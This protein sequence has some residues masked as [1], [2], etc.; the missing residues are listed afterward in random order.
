MCA[1]RKLNI[2]DVAPAVEMFAELLEQ[3]SEFQSQGGEP[4]ASMGDFIRS[5]VHFSF[6]NYIIT[7]LTVC[8]F[9]NNPHRVL[10]LVVWCRCD[11][12]QQ[13]SG[14]MLMQLPYLRGCM[15]SVT[16]WR[17]SAVLMVVTAWMMSAWGPL[18]YTRLFL[19]WTAHSQGLYPNF[20]YMQCTIYLQLLLRHTIKMKKQMLLSAGV[21]SLP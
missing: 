9:N 4:Y 3:S 5:E 14:K 10:L 12:K 15:W 7:I 20:A 11:D 16:C 2:E 6:K 19:D 13:R 1:G 8:C 21:G 18:A 17:W